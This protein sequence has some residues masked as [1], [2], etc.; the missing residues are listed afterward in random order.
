MTRRPVLIQGG[1]TRPEDSV[2]PALCRGP[3]LASYRGAGEKR[4]VG[5]HPA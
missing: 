5:S 3:A 4:D 2:T 1:A